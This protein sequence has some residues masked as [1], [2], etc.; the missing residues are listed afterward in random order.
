MSKKIVYIAKRNSWFNEGTICILLEDYRPN[1]VNSGL[2]YGLRTCTN[3]ESENR[4]FGETF[5]KEE[6]CGFDEF[7]IVEFE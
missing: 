3:P 5:L 1:L 4:L 2:F 7:D 6:I